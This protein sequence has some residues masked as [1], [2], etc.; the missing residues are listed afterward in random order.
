MVTRALLLVAVLAS[1]A[2]AEDKITVG[3]YAPS[4]EF[5]TAQARLAFVQ[6]GCNDAGFID[7]AMLESEVDANFFGGRAGEKDLTAAIADVASYKTAQAVFA[8]V[9]APKGLTKV[10][11]TGTVPNP[12]FV[13]LSG[14]L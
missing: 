7:N 8:P 9:G 11:D 2:S 12:A 5:G 6:T 4:V 14:K 13:E 10:F 3:I 1:V